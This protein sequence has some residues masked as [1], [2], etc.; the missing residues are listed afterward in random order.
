MSTVRPIST[1][2]DRPH[3]RLQ[4]G[5]YAGTV[6]VS[7]GCTGLALICRVLMAGQHC[8]T[9]NC[10]SIARTPIF[11]ATGD[12]YIQLLLFAVA[13]VVLAVSLGLMVT[14][15]VAGSGR[16]TRRRGMGWVGRLL[17]LLFMLPLA[18]SAVTFGFRLHHFTRQTAAQSAQFNCSR[19]HCAH[20]GGNAVRHPQYLPAVRRIAPSLREAAGNVR[21]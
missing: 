3:R 8:T 15:V 9:A 6:G 16:P 10:L 12:R 2:R 13:T 21:R 20:I 7:A 11:C 5:V 4:S 14:I 17:D 18:T 19:T 1:R